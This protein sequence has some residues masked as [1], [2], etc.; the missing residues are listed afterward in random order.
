MQFHISETELNLRYKLLSGLIIPRPI[1]LVTTC[2]ASGR[3]N[4]A[5]FSFFNVL[6]HDPPLLAL[7]IYKLGPGELKDTVRNIRETG[8][9]IVNLVGFEMAEQMNI[10]SVEF[11]FDADE[12]EVAGLTAEQGAYVNA[13]RI[14]ESPVSLECIIEREITLGDQGQRSIILGTIV[15]LHVRDGILNAQHHADISKLD[16]VGRLSGPTYAR[17][18]DTFDMPAMTVRDWERRQGIERPNAA[19]GSSRTIDPRL[20]M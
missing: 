10:C 7:G 17:L 11:P 20:S 18:T 14:L 9:F 6:S 3:V 2:S 8:H 16:V 1:A 19:D 4:A 5:P 15:H 13:P 12:I